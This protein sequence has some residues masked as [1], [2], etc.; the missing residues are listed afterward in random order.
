[1]VVLG[2]GGAAYPPVW[3]LGALLALASRI[4]D[5]RDKWTGLG[6]PV[7]LTVVGTAVGL[8]VA[9]SQGTLGHHIHD[10]WMFA[11]ISSRV[12]AVLG[13][14]Y[15]A[16]RSVRDRVPPEIPPWNKPHRVA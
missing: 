10:A 5:Y 15:L 9:G 4:W 2:A 6:L 11:V 12:S 1:V 3:L 7:L 13:A 8:A 16:W 14:A